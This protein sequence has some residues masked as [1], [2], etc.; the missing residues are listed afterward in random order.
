MSLPNVPPGPR[1][2]SIRRAIATLACCAIELG[3]AGGHASAGHLFARPFVTLETGARPNAVVLEDLNRDGL[4]DVV[5]AAAAEVS[6]FLG[7]GESRFDPRLS[8]PTGGRP[9]SVDIADFNGDRSADIVV[10]NI[11]GSVGILDGRGDGTFAPVRLFAAG[12]ECYG[13]AIGDLNEDGFPD[14]V[15]TTF[16]HGDVVVQLGLGDGTIGP[17]SHVPAASL[18]YAVTLADLNGDDHLDLAVANAGSDVAA[19]SVL[20]GRGDGT[21]GPRADF[22][23]S[24]TGCPNTT[25]GAF[26]VD[27]ADFDE[28]GNVDLAFALANCGRVAVLSGRGDGSFGPLREFASGGGSISVAAGDLDGDSHADLAVAAGAL[29]DLTPGI[30]SILL[31]HGDGTFATRRSFETGR[32][33]VWVDI[34]DVNGDGHLDVAASNTFSN[35]VALLLNSPNHPPECTAALA[36][37][38]ELRPPN[39]QLVPIAISGITDPD[40]DPI[41]IRVSAVSQDEPPSTQGTCPDAVVDQAGFASVRAER[42]GSGNGRV[43]AIAFTADD[44]SGG[45]CEGVVRVCVP[46]DRGAESG[47]HDDGPHFNSLGPCAR[48]AERESGVLE[49]RAIRRSANAVVVE[50]HV[51]ETIPFEVA[52]YDVAGRC[53][54]RADDIS[55]GR[56]TRSLRLPVDRVSRGVYFC[57]MRTRHGVMATTPFILR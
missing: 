2:S 43:Y 19:G 18:P 11:T 39:H 28:D 1:S 37:L 35:S 48:D 8:F 45:A 32:V 40:G 14:V 51:P 24:A 7:R 46:R 3:F 47:C 55:P 33:T 29:S 44:G 38:A 49:L 12:G 27:A 5:C 13:M 31:G 22:P 10:A 42:E 16:N 20:M 54:A 6:V 41:S 25:A 56:G 21:F 52:L 4:L 23:A 36:E 57:R 9:F 34:G 53:I 50:I 15:T 26:S 30:V 17:A